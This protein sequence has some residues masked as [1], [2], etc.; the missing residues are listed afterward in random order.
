[1]AG[2]PAQLWLLVNTPTADTSTSKTVWLMSLRS[3]GDWKLHPIQTVEMGDIN[4]LSV[5]GGYLYAMG[6]L[7]DGTAYVNSSYRWTL[8]ADNVAPAYASSPVINTTG[9]FTPPQFG[10]EL[11]ETQK[12]QLAMTFIVE[13]TDAEHT[14]GVK[15]GLDGASPNTTSLGTINSASRVQTLYFNGI[16]TPE[17]NAISHLLQPELTFTTDDTVSPKL[18]AMALHSAIRPER[19]RVWECHVEVGD[20][21]LLNNGNTEPVAK[22][23][24][25]SSLNTLEIQVY[26]IAFEHDLDQDGVATEIRVHILDIAKEPEVGGGQV[27]EGVEVWRLVLQEADVS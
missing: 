27:R 11:P 19:F 16:T 20:G 15:F 4:E 5:N 25:L 21:L 12:A 26:P 14:I 17:S 22:A 2:D 24:V 18:H 10:F 8:P 13:D 9:T 7:Y 1:M 3:P 6:R 23:A